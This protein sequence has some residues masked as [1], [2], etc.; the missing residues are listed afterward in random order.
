MTVGTNKKKR[1]VLVEQ[2]VNAF[3]RRMY[4]GLDLK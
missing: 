3:C 1:M 4:A 2:Y